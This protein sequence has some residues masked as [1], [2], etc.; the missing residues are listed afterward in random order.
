V[1]VKYHNYWIY[2]WNLIGSTNASCRTWS[3]KKKK[4]DM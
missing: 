4:K 3:E 2:L 1:Q